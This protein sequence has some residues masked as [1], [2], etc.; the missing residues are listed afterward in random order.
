MFLFLVLLWLFVAL[1][2]IILLFT[3]IVRAINKRDVRRSLITL[4]ILFV[5]GFITTLC[6]GITGSIYSESS[7][8]KK[9][10]NQSNEKVIKEEKSNEKQQVEK[11]EQESEDKQPS[12]D[13]TAENKLKEDKEDKTKYDLLRSTASE[14]KVYGKLNDSKSNGQNP[15]YDKEDKT[16]YT[17]GENKVILQVD[18]DFSDLPLDTKL[19]SNLLKQHAQDYMEYDAELIQKTN[20]NEFKYYSKNLNKNYSVL[21]S[22]NAKGQVISLIISSF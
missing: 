17:L 14:N 5:V 22:L 10:D 2:F 18:K 15:Y 8:S 9:K 3:T 13:N 4:I 16:T 20:S 12:K 7:N 6:I 1:A 19:D 11:T 21:Y